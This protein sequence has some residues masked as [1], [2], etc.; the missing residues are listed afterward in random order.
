MLTL[1]EIEQYSPVCKKTL[2][3]GQ[4]CNSLNAVPESCDSNL[5]DTMEQVVLC[6]I[7]MVYD[8]WI[9]DCEHPGFADLSLPELLTS[10]KLPLII[11][12]D[13]EMIHLPPQKRDNTLL[14][15]MTTESVI[16]ESVA[17]FEEKMSNRSA[18]NFEKDLAGIFADNR[19]GGDAC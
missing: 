4:S 7:S 5:P 3:P 8:L 12:N 6:I 17:L 13:A 1:P 14:L 9:I 15:N 18:R 19:E 10:Q 2:S 11:S 16:T